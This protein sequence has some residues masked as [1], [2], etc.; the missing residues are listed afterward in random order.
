M[1]RGMLLLLFLAGCAGPSSE[2]AAKFQLGD[3]PAWRLP[4]FDD[5]DWPQRPPG[6]LARD[7]GWWWARQ[8]VFISERSHGSGSLALEI[9]TLGSYEVFWDGA[10][11]GRNGEPGQG[12]EREAPGKHR[13]LFLIPEDLATPG[14]HLLAVRI[15]SFWAQVP[16]EY[17]QVSL[18]PLETLILS[19]QLQAGFFFTVFGLLLVAGL[20]FLAYRHPNEP[21]ILRFGWLCLAVA[22]LLA[23]EYGKFL[24]NYSYAYHFYRLVTITFLTQ[25]VCVLLPW[26]LMAR[27]QLRHP[28]FLLGVMLPLLVMPFLWYDPDVHCLRMF[29][30]SLGYSLILGGVGV[31][32]GRRQWRPLL[33]LVALT[34][35]LSAFTG[36]RFADRWFFPVFLLLVGFLAARMLWESR[37][38]REALIAEQLESARLKLELLR[39]SIQPHFLKNT[40]AAAMG[41]IEENPEKGIGLLESLADELDCFF[42]I[43]DRDWVGLEEEL[44][45]CRRH[46]ATMALV[47][48]R[49]MSLHFEGPPT[50]IAIPP[51]LLITCVENALTHGRYGT[52]GGE[53]R[54]RME[55]FQGG[56]RLAVRNLAEPMEPE[57]EGT[58]TRYLRALLSKSYPGAWS[59]HSG[60]G[61]GFW[62]TLITVEGPRS[63]QGLA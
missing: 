14:S 61:K 1:I 56:W 58:G 33:W 40:L 16:N 27:F 29:Q 63:N 31:A 28:G 41:W 52:E 46:V 49:P 48:D 57:R 38:Q 8:A 22:V 13:G 47:M 5:G 19:R 9:R 34:F 25:I 54:V 37:A 39:K 51:G 7:V 24:V 53:V 4:D 23:L 59:L 35:A 3:D 36:E 21:A 26:F 62:E 6:F 2:P 18:A 17:F 55:P 20:F 43:G 15:S 45:L 30:F 44:D 12:R 32:K 42:K 60:Y 11:I 50:A 10:A